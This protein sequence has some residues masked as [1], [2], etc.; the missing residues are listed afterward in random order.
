MELNLLK[1][2][3]KAKRNL[4]NRKIKT[5]KTIQIAECLEKIF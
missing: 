4:K 2:C 3:P 1:K 5:N